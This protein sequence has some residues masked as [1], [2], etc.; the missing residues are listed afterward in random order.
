MGWSFL[1]NIKKAAGR[2]CVGRPTLFLSFIFLFLLV[3]IICGTLVF[4]TDEFLAELL[5]PFCLPVFF[6]GL[7]MLFSQAL[8]AFLICYVLF[9]NFRCP[10]SRL[11]AA[12]LML[13]YSL[14]IAYINF[15]FRNC[16][17]IPAACVLLVAAGL[18]FYLFLRNV[19]GRLF[20][21]LLAVSGAFHLYLLAVTLFTLI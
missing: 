12:V 21:F 13:I 9:D 20:A 17:I 3:G 5:P 2:T 10:L 11:V 19:S 14:G 15:F 6:I 8:I 1:I 16:L 18:H 7:L 4:R